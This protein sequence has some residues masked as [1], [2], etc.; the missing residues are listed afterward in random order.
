[1]GRSGGVR[2][3]FAPDGRIDID[4]EAYREPG[5]WMRAGDAVVADRPTSDPIERGAAALAFEMTGVAWA[6]MSNV[7]KAIWRAAVSRVMEIVQ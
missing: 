3:W 7:R 2:R 1:M 4:Y 6:D 5:S